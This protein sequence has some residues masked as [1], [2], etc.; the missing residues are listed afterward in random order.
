[1]PIKVSPLER[2]ALVALDLLP[3]EAGRGFSSIGW[4]GKNFTL[5]P[6]SK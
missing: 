3:M 5:S 2:S 1:M 6:G 4:N